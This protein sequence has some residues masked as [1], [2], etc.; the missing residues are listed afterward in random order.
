[1]EDPECMKKKVKIAPHDYSKKNYLATFIPQKQLTPEQIFWSDELLKKKAKALKEQA[2]SVKLIIAMTVYPPNTPRITPTSLTEG[3]RGFKQT[4]TCYL[5]VVIPFFK[6]IKE[7]FEGIQKALINEIKEMK[8]VFDQM[9]AEVDQHAVDKKCNEIEKKNILIENKNLIVECLSKDVFY[10]ATD[11]VLTVSRSSDMHDAYT[12]AQKHIAELEAG[13]SNLTHKIQKDDND[14]MIKHFSKLEVE[15]LNLQLKYQH[16]KE[17]EF[18]NLKA[19]IKRKMTCVTMPAD[20]L[21]VLTLGMYAIDVEPI[22]SRNRNNREVHLDYLKHLRESVEILCEIVEEDRE[23]LEY[24]IGTCPKHFNKRDK[25]IAT[26]PLNKKKR[27]T[28]V[29]LGVK[30]STA[31]SGSKPKSNTKKDKTLPAKSDMKKVEDHSRNNKS[32]V[33]QTNRADSSIIYKRTIINSNSNSVCKTCNKW[34][35]SFNQDKCVEKSF[36]FVKKPHA[37]KPTKRK[38]TL[39]ERCPLTRFTISKVVPVKQLESVSTSEIMITERLSNTSQKP[40]TR[41]QRKNKQEKAISTDTPTT[42]VTQSIDDFVKL[43]VVQIILWYFD[44]GCSTHMTGDHSWLRN[45][46]KKFT[47]IVRFGN[48]HFGAIM[49]YGDY[50]IGDSVI[51]MVYYVEGLRHNLFSVKQFCDSD[52]EVAFRKHSC[53]V[54]DVNGVELIKGNCGTNLYTIFVKDMMKS[55]PIYLLSKASKNKSW[56]WHRRLN[57]LNFGTINDLARKDLV[58]G[59]PRLK[60]EKDHLCSACQLGK[61]Q[62]YSHKPK[63]ENTNLEVLNTLHMDLCGPMR[64]QTINGKKYILVIVDDYSREDLGKLRPTVDIGIFVGEISFGLVPNPVLAAPYVPPTN[65]ELAIL[66]QPIFDEYFETP[67]VEQPVPPA[68]VVQVPIISAGTPSSTTIDQDTPSTSHSPSSLEVQPP[69]SHQGV[70]VDH[71]IENNPFAQADNDPFKNVFAPE[72]SSAESSSGDVSAAESDQLIQPHDHL[73]KWS[74]DHPM[75]NIIGNPS[76]L[77]STRKQLAIDALWCF[78]NS[79]LSKVELKK[80]KSAVTKDC[81]FKA[82]QEQIHQFD[83]LQNKAWLVAKGYRQEDGIDFEE[84]F[85][86]VER[87]EAIRIFIANTASKTITIYQMDVKTTFLNDELQKEVYVNQPE[88]FVDPDHPTH[89][90]HLKKALY[91]LKQA[92]QAC[93]S[94]S[95]QFLGD[96]L[97]SWSSKNQKNTAISTTKAEYIAISVIALCCNNVQHSRSKHIDIR[98]HFIREQVENG[99]VELYFVKTEYQLADIFTKALPRVLFEFLLPRLGMKSISPESLTCLQEE[100]NELQPAFQIEESMLSKRQLFLATGKLL[101]DN[102]ANENVPAPAPIRTDDQI[103][104]FGKTS[105][106]DRPRYPVLQMLWAIITRT[107]VDYAELIWEEFIQVIQTFLT[108][109]ANLGIATKKDKKIKPYVIPYCWFTKL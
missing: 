94:G 49:G 32:S 95:A 44:S 58:R 71:T 33:K 75:E 100:E 21:K 36:K 5:T 56:L 52:L 47:G 48:D 25:K 28:F 4:K 80:F 98:H 11:S 89:V 72:L 88:G 73:R 81:W 70:V 83:R 62:K 35:M 82:M 68:L 78:Y 104:P 59:L 51:S 12:V 105:R 26:A 34:L 31:A 20:K 108:D 77:V 109:K 38:F 37:N 15:H 13:N 90:Y 18:E 16:L 45:F 65:K 30:D 42:T 85:A 99:V 55:S 97:V 23:L 101:R 8:E 29:E 79:L 103:L 87:I 61:S 91:G 46:M 40:L 93:T 63:S 6:T 27:V 86:P 102:M 92:P 14:E 3:E 57:H 96:K 106:Y 9:E 2:K 69:I 66:F 1:M 41:Y 17:P 76:C 10:T 7:H 84:S 39:R 22:P 60:F 67:S 74:K 24:V 43:S 53:Y 54:R 19:Q 107:N 50:V 64:V